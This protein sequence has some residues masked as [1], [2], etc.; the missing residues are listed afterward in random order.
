[1][2]VVISLHNDQL[3]IWAKWNLSLVPEDRQWRPLWSWDVCHGLRVWHLFPIFGSM[4]PPYDVLLWSRSTAFTVLIADE[5]T[6]PTKDFPE[7]ALCDT[8]ICQASLPHPF[9]FPG[10][11][12][13]GCLIIWAP[14]PFRPLEI[15]SPCLHS[16]SQFFCLGPHSTMEMGA[17]F[18]LR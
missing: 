11:C 9:L 7:D 2:S 6:S 1:M 10:P 4:D 12:Y 3:K 15:P 5:E 18:P 13:S 14:L 17:A 8:G 16:L